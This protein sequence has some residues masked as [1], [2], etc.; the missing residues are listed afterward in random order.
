MFDEE[1]MTLWD[2]EQNR[3]S[4]DW[5][6]ELVNS[7]YEDIIPSTPYKGLINQGNTCFMNS[8]LQVLYMTTR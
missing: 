5:K 8:V 4:S 7:D 6:V 3:G 1:S 2:P